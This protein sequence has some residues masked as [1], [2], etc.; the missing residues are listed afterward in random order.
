MLTKL[1]LLISATILASALV[2]CDDNDVD[3]GDEPPPA[4]SATQPAAAATE[5]PSGTAAPEP[6][7]TATPEGNLPA[8]LRAIAQAARE[9]GAAAL[10]AF[11]RYGPVPCTTTITGIGGPPQCR[12]GEPEG[13][14]V[15]AVFVT[16][17]EGYYAREGE[18]NF[19]EIAFGVFG[20]GDALYGVYELDPASQLAR[21]EEWP[22]A[23]Y[24]IVLNR[25]GPADQTFVYA[26]ISDGDAI[27]GTATGC[28]ETP[29]E[30]VD[31]QGL[32]DPIFAP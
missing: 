30:W 31:F 11:V 32:S 15:D 13:T 23:R 12:E 9:N 25:I 1:A 22:G 14:P 3:N 18:L 16:T 2:A 10:E 19:A 21:I 17:C 20:N 29:E 8:G 28:G 4:T 7:T 24:V 27:L 26:I 5:R 6:E